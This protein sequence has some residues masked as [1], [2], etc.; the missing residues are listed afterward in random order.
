[1]TFTFR[2]CCYRQPLW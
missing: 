1:V 2:N